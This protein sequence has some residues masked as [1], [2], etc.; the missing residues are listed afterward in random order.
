MKKHRLIIDIPHGS[1]TPLVAEL[2]EVAL[3]QFYYCDYDKNLRAID[4]DSHF[5]DER[6]VRTGWHDE[7]AAAR[8]EAAEELARRAEQLARL[9]EA[10][11]SGQEVANV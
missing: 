4:R 8:A 9:H 1:I 5:Y 10:C 3:G 7:P 11:M 2:I 6:F